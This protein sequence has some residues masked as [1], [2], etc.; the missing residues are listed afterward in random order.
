MDESSILITG[1]GGQLGT[2]LSGQYPGARAAHARDLDI[3][4]FNALKNYAWNGIKIIL[5]AA[6]YTNVDGAETPEG[7]VEAWKANASG[8]ANLVRIAY[9]HQLTLVHVSTEYVFDGSQE[10]H[11]EDEPLSPLGVYAQSKA[12]G[13]IA[14]GLAPKHY[15]LRTSWVIGEGKNF[16]RTMLDLGQ[17]GVSPSV[18]NDQ[19]GRLTFTT[20]LARAI[21]HL[22]K[23]KPPYGIYN[24]SG[25]GELASWA[26]VTREIFNHAGFDLTV[27]D[28]TTAEYFKDKPNAAPRP[29]NS[30][31]DLSKI[32]ATGLELKDWREGL[33]EYVKKEMEKS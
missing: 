13:E 10:E 28:T 9:E 26:E 1:A 14:A 8:M 23:T 15:I 18:V 12:A 30:V 32:K 5:N 19:I 33:R 2:A 31:F 6:A 3:A 29:L 22:L 17:K 20:E 25:G 7:R 11:K 21:N 24:F 4:D 16:V 27:T